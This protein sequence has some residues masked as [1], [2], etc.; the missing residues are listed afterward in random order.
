M[1]FQKKL[2]D[3]TAIFLPAGNNQARAV[4]QKSIPANMDL[5][6][7][8]QNRGNL[9]QKNII[10]AGEGTSYL[11]TGRQLGSYGNNLP[12]E[13]GG[14]T[15]YAGICDQGKSLYN[16]HCHVCHGNNAAGNGIMSQY[17]EY[18]VM[19]PLTNEK[20]SKYPLGQL[21]KSIAGGQGNMPAFRKKITAAEIWALCAYIK[22]IQDEQKNG[23]HGK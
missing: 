2:D 5:S 4:P 22:F 7:D 16:T 3:Q 6:Y 8:E 21:F 10:F 19:E 14:M 17:P 13:L 9:P 12:I 18:P 1:S 23:Q 20:F 15:A 11:M